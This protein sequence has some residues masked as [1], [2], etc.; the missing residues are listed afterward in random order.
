MKRFTRFMAL[1][2]FTALHVFGQDVS[3]EW[4]GSLKAGPQELRVVLK[5]IRSDNGAWAATLLSID[6]SP[7]RGVGMAATSFSLDGS[8]VKFVVGQVQGSYE[9]K[10]SADGST[11]TGTWTQLRSLPLEFRRAT[12]DTA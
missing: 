9:G 2:A 12:K 4:Q 10:L 11:I 3:G 5:V 8:T 6:Q 7:D 1:A